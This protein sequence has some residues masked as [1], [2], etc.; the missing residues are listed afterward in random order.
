[1]FAQMNKKID[2]NFD[3]LLSSNRTLIEF[4]DDNFKP[5]KL[6]PFELLEQNN[7]FAL[8]NFNRKVDSENKTYTLLNIPINEMNALFK[9]EAE[10]AIYIVMDISFKQ[11]RLFTNALGIPENTSKSDFEKMDFDVLMWRKND[12]EI[13]IQHSFISNKSRESKMVTI[14]H[15]NNPLDTINF[16][17]WD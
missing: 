15:V 5:Y 7:P 12:L 16:D 4:I 10:G 9:N 8:R 14:S 3:T 17:F 6:T 11:L 1:L 13:S 2:L